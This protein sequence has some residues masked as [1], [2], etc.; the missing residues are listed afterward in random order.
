MVFASKLSF[1]W[2]SVSSLNLEEKRR[3]ISPEALVT[4]VEKGNQK[5][6]R[7]YDQTTLITMEN[8]TYCLWVLKQDLNAVYAAWF[9]MLRG[10][11]GLYFGGLGWPGFFTPVVSYAPLQSIKEQERPLMSKDLKPV[12]ELNRFVEMR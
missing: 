9:E 4:G 5:N 7:P 2:P 3:V 12:K 8:S 11:P 6:A 1:L 10:E